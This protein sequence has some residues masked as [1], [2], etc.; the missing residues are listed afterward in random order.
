M[1]DNPSLLDV[2]EPTQ[3]SASTGR[4]LRRRKLGR[5]TLILLIVLRIYVVVAIPIVA[6][7]F[8]RALLSSRS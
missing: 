3:L 6:Y 4:P 8:I 5:G 7:A 2:L 1:R